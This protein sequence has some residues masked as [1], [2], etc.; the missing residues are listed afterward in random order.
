MFHGGTNFGYMNGANILG[1][2]GV[3][4]A[5]GYVPDVTSYDYDA[6]LTEAG[7]VI[8]DQLNTSIAFP[9]YTPKYLAAKEMIAEYDPLY[10]L[11]AHPEMPE[12]QSPKVKLCLDI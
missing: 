2:N 9:Q 10:S 7:Q 5:P 3:E 1:F 6:P 4:T 8:K 12:I 11:L